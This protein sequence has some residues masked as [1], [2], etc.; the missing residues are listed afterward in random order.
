[1]LTFLETNAQAETLKSSMA[2]NGVDV[3]SHFTP[4]EMTGMLRE[5]GFARIEHL[6]TAEA[7]ERYF[8]HRSDGLRAPEIQRLARAT[9]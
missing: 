1:M 3:L 2:A 5:A 7:D 8:Q 6:T 4:A 9:T